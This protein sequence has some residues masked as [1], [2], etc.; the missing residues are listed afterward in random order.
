MELTRSFRFGPE[1][2]AIA[3]ILLFCKQKSPQTTAAANIKTK[4]WIPYRIQ[5]AG[6][7][8]SVTTSSLIDTIAD[9]G[10]VTVLAGSNVE[11]SYSI[12]RMMFIT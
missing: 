11:V 7:A 5:G 1:I 2:A 8:G 10:S 4:T 3:N 6:P 9:K 12:L